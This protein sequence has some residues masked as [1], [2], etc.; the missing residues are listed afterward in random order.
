MTQTIGVV[1]AGIVGMAVARELA[2]RGDAE[3]VV[4]DKG[5][6][7]ARHQTGGRV[8]SDSR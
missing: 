1:G 4:L 8:M 7:V 5:D 2:R 6:R 3:V